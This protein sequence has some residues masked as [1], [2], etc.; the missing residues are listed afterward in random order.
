MRER[1]F[2][3]TGRQVPE[4]VVEGEIELDEALVLD[5]VADEAG[6]EEAHAAGRPVVV[7][8]ADPESVTRALARPEVACVVVPA[9]RHDLLELDLR[10]LTYG[11]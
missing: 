6:L 3:A 11:Q 4:I 5:D 2:G 9:S 1:W 7:R 10:K 8:A